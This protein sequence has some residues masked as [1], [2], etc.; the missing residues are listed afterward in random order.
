MPLTDP[1]IADY[2]RRRGFYDTLRSLES[3]VGVQPQINYEHLE[4]IIQDRVAYLSHSNVLDDSKP[5]N[6]V[7]NGHMFPSWSLGEELKGEIVLSGELVIHSSQGRLHDRDV[8]FLSCG[9]GLK[10]IDMRGKIIRS[11]PDISGSVLKCCYPIGEDRVLICGMDGVVKLVSLEDDEPK[12]VAQHQLHARLVTDLKVWGNLMFSIGWDSYLRV[13]TLEDDKLAM[14]SEFKL[15]SNATALEVVSLGSVPIALVTRMDSSQLTYFSCLE[16]LV[17]LTRVSL[18]DAEFST[19]GF[20]GMSIGVSSPSIESGTTVVVGTSHIPFMRLVVTKA[21]D[22]HELVLSKGVGSLNN[23]SA[24][25]LST[26]TQR[27]VILMNLVTPS[28]QD[29]FSHCK[30]IFRADGTGVWIFGDDGIIRGMDLRSGEVVTELKGHDGRIKSALVCANREVLVTSG[31]DK[32]VM[33][34]S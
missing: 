1:L 10:C 14:L 34:W 30:V 26:P 23:T 16:S 19:H 3:H 22:L 5:N 11:Y 9:R 8:V 21:P 4:T 12:P 27:G 25:E 18:N 32:Q 17:E 2:L 28:P 20:T 33:L 13:H 6:Q 7:E 29:K 31:T 15:L 24:Q